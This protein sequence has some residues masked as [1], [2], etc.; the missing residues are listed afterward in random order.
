MRAGRTRP[1]TTTGRGL[2]GNLRQHCPTWLLSG[3]VLLLVIA[4]AH[5]DPIWIWDWREG[6]G[7]VWATFRS[8]LDRL[9]ELDA[10]P[11]DP[12]RRRP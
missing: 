7:E 3:I 10:T 5:M 6:F 9:A 11:H 2:A 1:R 4:N 12:A 8:A